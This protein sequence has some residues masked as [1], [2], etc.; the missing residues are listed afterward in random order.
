MA[1]TLCFSSSM[2]HVKTAIV[3]TMQEHEHRRLTMLFEPMK[4][5]H[6]T[7]HFNTGTITQKWYPVFHVVLLLSTKKS[8]IID[9]VASVSTPH[10]E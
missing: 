8:T 2:S 3:H 1:A 5:D 6:I 7:F 10:L 9:V 4:E